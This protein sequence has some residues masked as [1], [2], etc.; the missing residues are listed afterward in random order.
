M[1]DTNFR[2]CIICYE[3][4]FIKYNT[5]SKC[6]HEADVCLECI[7][8]HINTNIDKFEIKSQ[9]NQ[10]III[11]ITCPI[12]ICNKP[13]ERNDIK[14]IATKDIYKRFNNF[15]YQERRRQNNI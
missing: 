10:N 7:N 13:M 8:K 15:L 6:I 14:K 5:T 9:F 2:E 11:K 1:L 4:K 12:Q 3:T